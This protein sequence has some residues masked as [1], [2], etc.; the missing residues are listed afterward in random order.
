MFYTS[1]AILKGVDSSEIPEALKDSKRKRKAM[2][3]EINWILCALG[4]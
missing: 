2:S 4:T 3:G 1:I